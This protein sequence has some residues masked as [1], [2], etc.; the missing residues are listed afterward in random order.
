M[1]LENPQEDALSDSQSEQSI[2][3]YEKGAEEVG[4]ANPMLDRF[5]ETCEESKKLLQKGAN[6]KAE[7]EKPL[8]RYEQQGMVE[9]KN[10]IKQEVLTLS[11]HEFQFGVK[12]FNDDGDEYISHGQFDD[13]EQLHG[14][15][16]QFY[17]HH[18]TLIEGQFEGNKL[19]GYARMIQ[20]ISGDCYTGMW[21]L[22]KKNGK[23][24]FI[25]GEGKL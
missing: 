19:Q 5:I 6:T 4:P 10:L 13:K 22:G 9:W 14:I 17:I 12:G 11:E 21:K 25:E 1:S 3:G 24:K 20:A 16:T 7:F 23:G 15:G 8:S 18:G 2:S